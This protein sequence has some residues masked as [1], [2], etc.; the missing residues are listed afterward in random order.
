MNESQV[1]PNINLSTHQKML[2]AKIQSTPMS[3]KGGKR[4]AFEDEKMITARDILLKLGIITKDD[5]SG[6]F[7]LT[8]RAE[9]LMQETGIT[10][11]SGELTDAGTQ[12]AAGE[13]PTDSSEDSVGDIQK[14]ES[15][16]ISFK[17]YLMIAE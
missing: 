6:L 7:N 8:D 4:V 15:F 14:T 12:L 9:V 2:L 13:V 3:P 1:S 11:E 5:E 10:D 16:H 17:Q